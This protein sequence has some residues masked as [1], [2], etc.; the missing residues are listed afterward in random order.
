[1]TIMHEART[2]VF[3]RG[4]QNLR[5]SRQPYEIVLRLIAGIEEA[6]APPVGTRLAL[7]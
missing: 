2:N 6:P 1:M 3:P 7:P 4:H 5:N